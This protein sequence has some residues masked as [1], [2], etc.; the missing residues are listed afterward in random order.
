[1]LKRRERGKEAAM[2]MS[3]GK[4]PLAF[5][6]TADAA[7]DIEGLAVR[8][9]FLCPPYFLLTIITAAGRPPAEA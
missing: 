7:V 9:F 6:H 8:F 5:G 3:E 2:G 1:M 4:Q